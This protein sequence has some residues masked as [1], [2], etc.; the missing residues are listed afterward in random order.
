VNDI[1]GAPGW[2]W[3]GT[4]SF[5][6]VVGPHGESVDLVDGDLEVEHDEHGKIIYIPMAVLDALLA[7]KRGNP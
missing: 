5:E 2:R 4:E 1:E 3:I 6:M 7:R